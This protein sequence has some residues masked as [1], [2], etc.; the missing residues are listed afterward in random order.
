MIE[1]TNQLLDIFRKQEVSAIF[2]VDTTYLMRLKELSNQHAVCKSDFNQVA[3]QLKQMIREGHYVYPHIHPHWLDAIYL[4][5]MNQWELLNVQRYRFHKISDADKE[6]VF[7]GS[8]NILKEILLTEFPDYK[9]DGFRAGG[10]SL[11][12]FSDFKPFF[13]KYG[14]RYDFS[15]LPGTYQFSNAQHFDFTLAPQKPVYQFEDDVNIENPTGSF[16]ELVSS[17]LHVSAMINFMH[18]MHLHWLHKVARDHTYG[19]GQG[20]QSIEDTSQTPSNHGGSSIH[21]TQHQP[22]SIETMSM[23]KIILYSRYLDSHTYMQFVSHPKMLSLHSMRTLSRFL[24]KAKRKYQVE[25][26]FKSFIN[27][28][29]ELY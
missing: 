2:F 17:I 6:T 23:V 8:I 11:Q 22:V 20:Q 16:I 9:V 15:V 1:P 19:K 4:P 27:S 3:N 13:I 18:K 14:I 7:S 24:M 12:P 26:D 21:N 5:D 10:W 25:F 28:A 29:K